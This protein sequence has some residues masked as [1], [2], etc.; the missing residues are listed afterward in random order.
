MSAEEYHDEPGDRPHVTDR[1]EQGARVVPS[2]LA[3]HSSEW[4]G[5]DGS[6]GA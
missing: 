3:D 5:E 1:Q 4:H 6:H 2:L